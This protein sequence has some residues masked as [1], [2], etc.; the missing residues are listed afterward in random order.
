MASAWIVRLR[1]PSGERR[2]EVRFRVGGRESAQRYAGSFRTRAEAIERRRWLDGEL[3]AMRVPDLSALQRER[4]R[5]PTL[6]DAAEAYRALADRHRRSN[7]SQHRTSLKLIVASLDAARRVDVFTP[8]EIAD[9][10]D[11]APRVWLQTRDDPEGCDPPG[12]RLRLRRGR[13]QSSPRQGAGAASRGGELA[14]QSRRAPSTLRPCTGCCPRSIG[15]LCSGSTGPVRVSRAS[16]RPDRRLRRAASA[17]PSARR[18]LQDPARPLG[19]PPRRTCR[20]DRADAAAARGPRSRSPPVRR[21]RCGCDPDEHRE[22]VSRRRRA[23]LVAARPPASPHQPPSS[24]GADVGG[25][26]CAR[27]TALA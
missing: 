1:T 10:V 22:S 18:S 27:R 25:D 9:A 17:R 19:G 5:A 13:A 20:G 12:L 6:A 14:S 26:R 15:S 2:H 7:A 4:V 23:A 21:E 3:A 8:H 16:T 24:A 11:T